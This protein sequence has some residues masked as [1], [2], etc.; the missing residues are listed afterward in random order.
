MSFEWMIFSRTGFVIGKGAETRWQIS[1]S[2][3]ASQQALTSI[4]PGPMDSEGQRQATQ[5]VTW[6]DWPRLRADG[7]G[8]SRVNGDGF[9]ECNP[10]K[11]V[12]QRWNIHQCARS[13]DEMPL[14]ILDFRATNFPSI[15]VRGTGIGGSRD[16]AILATS[17]FRQS[18][19]VGRPFRMSCNVEMK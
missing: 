11:K 1:L 12:G 16:V 13:S 17:R 6:R 3:K 8:S 15:L 14:V 2:T 9:S 18:I 5:L 4:F 10:A 7:E 19:S